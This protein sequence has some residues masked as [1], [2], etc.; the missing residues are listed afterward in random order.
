M[1]ENILRSGIEFAKEGIRISKSIDKVEEEGEKYREKASGFNKRF[2]P[3]HYNKQIGKFR[4]QA[5][6]A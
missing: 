4:R 1:G 2:N 6:W 3:S 5:R